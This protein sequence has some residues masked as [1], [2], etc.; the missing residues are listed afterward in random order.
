MDGE[1]EE[2][3][4]PELDWGFMDEKGKDKDGKDSDAPPGYVC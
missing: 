4:E 2:Q 3:D 1:A